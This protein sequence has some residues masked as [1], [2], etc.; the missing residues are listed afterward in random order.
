[1]TR[2]RKFDL[3]PQPPLVWDE[4]AS[5]DEDYDPTD[6]GRKKRD[7]GEELPEADDEI[8]RIY[9]KWFSPNMVN[10]QG[11]VINWKKLLPKCG[12]MKG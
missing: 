7:S 1:M 12:K 6:V 5:F 4:K 9:W 3:P 11:K 10:F 8:A 2:I